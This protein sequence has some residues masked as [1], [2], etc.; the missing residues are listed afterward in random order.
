MGVWILSPRPGSVTRNRALAQSFT[1]VR[2]V[3]FAPIRTV[4]IASTTSLTTAKS[5]AIITSLV[6][7]PGRRLARFRYGPALMIPTHVQDLATAAIVS[8][9]ATVGV[10]L[11]YTQDTLPILQHYA[12]TELKESSD[13]TLALMAPAVG[14]YFG[15]VVRRRLG[16]ARWHAPQGEN[17]LWRLEAIPFFFAFNPVGTTLEVIA[18]DDRPG[19]GAHLHIRKADEER[20]KSALEAYGEVREEDY[21]SFS[22][23]FETIEQVTEHLA[24][25]IDPEKPVVYESEDYQTFV[26]AQADA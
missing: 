13:E 18:Q 4:S 24:R 23:R 22:V 5:C 21:Y 11:D 15:E 26:E 1:I 17:A 6:T 14:A 8:V 12:T 20:V 25:A 3:L 16:E 7:D 10:E 9:K 2:K 19:W